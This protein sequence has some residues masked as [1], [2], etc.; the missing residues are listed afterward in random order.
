MQRKNR[1]IK[2]TFDVPAQ[3]ESD[4][5]FLLALQDAMDEDGVTIDDWKLVILPEDEDGDNISMPINKIHFNGFEIE[6]E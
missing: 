2:I 5:E 1:Q 3:F 4:E 6:P